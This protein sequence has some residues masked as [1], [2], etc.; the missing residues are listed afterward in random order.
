MDVESLKKQDQ[1][2]KILVSGCKKIQPIGP[3]GPQLA[4]VNR[5]SKCG[6]RSRH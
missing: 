4:T 5:A 2:M 1:L 3:F 6:K